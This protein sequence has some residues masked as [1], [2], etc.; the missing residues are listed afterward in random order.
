MAVVQAGAAA[1]LLRGN[2]YRLRLAS[3]LKIRCDRWDKE[4]IG[5]IGFLPTDA[6]DKMDGRDGLYILYKIVIRIVLVATSAYYCGYYFILLNRR[7][8]CDIQHSFKT[9]TSWYL[10]ETI[11]GW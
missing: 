7:T 5:L 2:Q 9:S 1:P 6:M 3:S 11:S 8:M 10:R 4:L